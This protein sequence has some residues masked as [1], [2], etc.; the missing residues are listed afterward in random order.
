MANLL[1]F[2]GL[3]HLSSQPH[4]VFSQYGGGPAINDQERAHVI[5][6]KRKENKKDTTLHWQRPSITLLHQS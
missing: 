2:I 5:I 3:R 1:V 6:I 4:D